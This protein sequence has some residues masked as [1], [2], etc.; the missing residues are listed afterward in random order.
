MH[1]TCIDKGAGRV[2]E[3]EK[4]WVPIYEPGLD[5]L[6]A[7]NVRRGRLHFSTELSEA[8]NKADVLFIAVDTPQG[9]DGSADL[10]NVARAAGIPYQGF[11]RA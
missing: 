9:D 11:G 4:G 3:L 10:S 5:E 2:T 7:G 1:L 6:V 8:V